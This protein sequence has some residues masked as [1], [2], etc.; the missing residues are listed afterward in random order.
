MKPGIGAAGQVCLPSSRFLAPAGGH[1][2]SPAATPS[3]RRD[4]LPVLPRVEI[5]SR[6]YV[7]EPITL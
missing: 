7:Q 4:A 6:T 5:P 3:H 2:L 1:P